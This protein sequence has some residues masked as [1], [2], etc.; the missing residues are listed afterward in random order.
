VVRLESGARAAA[1]IAKDEMLMMS[2]RLLFVFSIEQSYEKNE[3][4]GAW[5]LV[6]RNF[7]L[8]YH[9]DKVTA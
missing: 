9:C 1:G 2:S 3:Y 6:G 5:W 8:P 4:K 7:N